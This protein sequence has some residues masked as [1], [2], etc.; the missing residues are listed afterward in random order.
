MSPLKLCLI[1]QM[2]SEICWKKHKQMIDGGSEKLLCE[3]SSFAT[4][5]GVVRS[6]WWSSSSSLR[7][8][9]PSCFIFTPASPKPVSSLSRIEWK[10]L[11]RSEHTEN[12]NHRPVAEVLIMEL[13]TTRKV[14]HIRKEK[15]QNEPTCSRVFLLFINGIYLFMISL[16]YD[17]N[18]NSHGTWLMPF[19]FHQNSCEHHEFPVPSLI[20]NIGTS[21]ARLRCVILHETP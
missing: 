14:Y 6:L 20:P 13:A 9:W 10:V 18:S 5:V 11:F 4:S 19:L 2:T 8:A 1:K 3:K 16:E 17:T 12:V 15:S 7:I 21:A